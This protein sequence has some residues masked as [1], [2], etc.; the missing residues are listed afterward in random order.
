MAP[1]EFDAVEAFNVLIDVSDEIGRGTSPRQILARTL[2]IVQRFTG[3]DAA[4]FVAVE[5]D[6]ARVVG[7]TPG[8][9]WLDGRYFPFSGSALATLLAGP[10]RSRMFDQSDTSSGLRRDLTGHGLEKVALA[11]VSGVRTRGALAVFFADPDAT[12]AGPARA[13]FEYAAAATGSL[14]WIRPDSVPYQFGAVAAAVPDGLA[15]L[16]PDGV[17]QS[18]NPAA[19]RLTG[20]SPVSAIG[21]RP[22]FAVPAPGQMLDTQLE[23]GRWIEVRSAA[24]DGTDPLVITFRDVTA[25]RMEEEGRDLFLATTSHE[26]RTPLTV[27]KGYADTLANRW[28]DL[29]EDARLTAVNAIRERTAQLAALVD[30]LL[31]ANRSESGAVAMERT[32]FDLRAALVTALRA[33]PTSQIRYRAVFDAPG[34]VPW[35]R[36]DRAS[37]ATII[38]EL[39]TNAD[40]YSPDGGEVRITVGHDATSVYFQVA[41]RGI[42]VA[43]EHMDAVFDRF[44]QA[45]RGD[46]RR[47]GGVG[48]GLY[49]IRRLLDRQGG[50]VALRARPGG[51]TVVEVRLPR[52]STEAA[53]PVAADG[54]GPRAP[55]PTEYARSGQADAVSRGDH[56]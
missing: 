16:D 38:N 30:R 4:C 31:L 51:G 36:G 19:H 27:V 52:V 23:S 56:E 50:W 6:A 42:G 32:P 55:A 35:A 44:W 49:I 26:L 11:R 40:K 47:F 2:E 20:I 34:H 25:P 22:P 1:A 41:D 18:W 17:V 29:D 12:L 3:A 54:G 48:L 10:D 53:D 33:S 15:V 28:D 14:A 21:R 37:V 43:P 8:A 45:E 9:A 39:L 7:T 46:Q 5:P 13:M 24:L